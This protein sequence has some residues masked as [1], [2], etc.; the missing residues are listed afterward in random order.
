MARM[1]PNIEP[2][3]VRY[4]GE[5]LVFRWLREL[6]KPY[7]V[8]HSVQLLQVLTGS[9]RHLEREADFVVL[10]PESGLLVIEV[11]GGRDIELRDGSWLRGGERLV[12]QP[13]EQAQRA[14]HLIVRWLVNQRNLP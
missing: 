2:S 6:P 3:D 1:I 12:P 8:F 13:T 4:P 14:M 5:R 9:E 11:K 10:H 7:V